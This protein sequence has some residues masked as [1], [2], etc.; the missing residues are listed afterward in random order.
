MR[1]NRGVF[2]CRS[3]HCYYCCR[4]C[5]RGTSMP[6]LPSSFAHCC[7]C[8]YCCCCFSVS[9]LHCYFL[10]HYYPWQTQKQ[11]MHRQYVHGTLPPQWPNCYNL[12]WI[13][14]PLP[15]V[16]DRRGG[17]RWKRRG[18]RQWCRGVAPLLGRMAFW[19]WWL[20]FAFLFFPNL[21]MFVVALII[22]DCLN[23]LSPT[24]D[25]IGGAQ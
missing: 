2:S 5:Q 22:I 12:V 10:Q 19:W 18:G 20:I 7:C 11:P 15:R 21:L 23:V 3:S 24:K 17:L 16:I 6:L 9:S 13:H 25:R 14:G 8:C 4:C 1:R